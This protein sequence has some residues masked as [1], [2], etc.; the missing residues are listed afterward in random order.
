MQ[1]NNSQEDYI[2]EYIITPLR[3]CTEGDKPQDK[4]YWGDLQQSVYNCQR[5]GMMAQLH[6]KMRPFY[7]MYFYADRTL[8]SSKQHQA[9]FFV[10]DVAKRDEEFVW[11][12][13]EQDLVAATD[14]WA[15]YLRIQDV[16]SHIYFR[17]LNVLLEKNFVAE[18]ASIA[19]EMTDNLFRAEVN[20]DYK[21]GELYC[22]LHAV[23]MIMKTDWSQRHKQEM[24]SLLQTTWDFLKFFY[25][26]MI[27]RII[28]CRYTNYLAV[29]NHMVAQHPEYHQYIHI[30]FC[31]LS[32]RMQSLGL[33]VKQYRKLEDKLEQIRGIMQSTM[34]SDELNDLCDALFPEEF[35]R[36]LYTYRPE[37][38]EQIERERNKLRAEVG[39][40]TAQVEK[41][42]NQLRE[43][44]EASVPFSYIEEQLMRLSPGMALDIWG[45]LNQLLIHN[46]NW[47]SHAASIHEK[48]LLKKEENERQLTEAF[49]RI[50]EQQDK[51]QEMNE[52][53]KKGLQEPR[54]KVYPQADSTTNIGCDQK[55]SD[56]KTYLSGTA[57]PDGG[58]ML[59]NNNED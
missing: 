22:I 52:E 39:L 12:A 49:Q 3:E 17:F 45:Q 21:T 38:Y 31:A 13:E 26:V 40:L 19:K 51:Q 25:S 4:V 43:A 41:L 1:Y 29:A 6:E 47:I 16:S 2:D 48:I 18:W 35:Q 59:E 5:W 28:G 20:C 30:F 7:E 11:W 24:L 14:A 37:T 32:D 53:V 27:R 8:F 50:A 44:V 54:I 46:P 42:I 33:N 9:H 34:L 10:E 55:G 15:D 56:F 57:V 36:L 58:A 23:S